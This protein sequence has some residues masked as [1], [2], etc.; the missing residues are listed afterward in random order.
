MASPLL[1]NGAKA[2]RAWATWHH[3]HSRWGARG[4]RPT[5]SDVRPTSSGRGGGSSAGARDW[6]SRRAGGGAARVPSCP[7]GA[8]GP[9]AAGLVARRRPG[10]SSAAGGRKYPKDRSAAVRSPSHL[11]DPRELPGEVAASVGEAGSR[12]FPP[13]H[14]R[15]VPVA[16]AEGRAGSCAASAATCRLLIRPAAAFWRTC[17]ALRRKQGGAV[18]P[19][20]SHF[21]LGLGGIRCPALLFLPSYQ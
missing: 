21:S 5:R 4:R 20:R 11:S 17:R 2:P 1:P 12:P 19:V 3:S 8:L 18:G 16:D 6:P 14:P 9:A 10:S 15:L 13:P 7:C